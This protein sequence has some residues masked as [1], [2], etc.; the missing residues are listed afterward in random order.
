MNRN[1]K[2]LIL[3]HEF[4]PVGGGGSPITFEL[5][6]QLVRMGHQVDVVTMHY[7]DLPRF[8][9]VEGINI[10]RTPAI[11]KRANISH[12]HELATYLPGA[13]FKTLSLAKQQKY[14]IIH[15]HFIIPGGPL[16]LTVSK[17]TKIPYI[18]TA[19]GSDVP[20][21][22]PDRFRFQHKFTKPVLKA[23]CRN[24]KMVT[25]PSLYLKNLILKNIG[26]YEIKHIPNG[27]DLENF[28][29]DLTRPRENI[30]LTTGRLLKRKGFQTLIRAVHDVELPFEVHI[31]GDGPY[32]QQLEKLAEGS[33][34]KIIFHGWLEKASKDL[35]SLY[36]RASIYVLVS[37]KENASVSLL[38]GMAAGCV[39][40]TTNVSGCPETVGDAAFLI[41]FDDSDRLKEIL[42]R[43]S[44]QKQ[45]LKEYAR[46]AYSRLTDNFLWDQIAA[47]YIKVYT[48]E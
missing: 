40:I 45:L 10:Y 36:E 37:A 1:L 15:C 46:K 21:Y 31:A 11:R 19:H 4:P 44:T 29:L 35:L 47:D 12:T 34:T 16:A 7:G 26:N 41:D 43:L 5:S 42:I 8:E 14:D 39:V 18:I 25:S 23:V 9:T 38:E 27:I 30:I 22:N 2:I 28:K 3:N 20:G 24:A 33:K 32:R 6:R 48:D 17:L 13:L